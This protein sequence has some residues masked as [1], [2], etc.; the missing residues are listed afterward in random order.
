M[1]VFAVFLHKTY[2]FV[3]FVQDKMKQT[4]LGEVIGTLCQERAKKWEERGWGGQ[5]PCLTNDHRFRAPLG[6]IRLYCKP[7][8][9][10]WRVHE[11]FG[12]FLSFTV[13]RQARTL[14][15]TSSESLLA[16]Q[17]H[18]N[19]H[20]SQTVIP[21]SVHTLVK[22]ST[23]G[24]LP[25]PSVLPDMLYHHAHLFHLQYMHFWPSLLFPSSGI[26]QCLIPSKK[27]RGQRQ[28]K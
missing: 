6:G 9:R 15:L 17:A 23:N 2:E 3:S 20:T 12:L 1:G 4:E 14:T 27:E 28:D 7:L 22:I 21:C 18:T 16:I 26:T 11:G 8:W 24:S 13:D 5:A 19:T 25:P 10:M